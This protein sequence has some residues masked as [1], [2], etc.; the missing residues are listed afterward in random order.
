MRSRSRS[1]LAL[2][3]TAA[4][5]FAACTRENGTLGPAPF[6]NSP[7]VFTDNFG[8]SV[9]FAAF[10]GSKVD[11]LSIDNT[12]KHSGSS[13][14]KITVPS[15]GDPAGSYA[16]GAF[17]VGVPRDLSS[18]NVLSFWAPSSATARARR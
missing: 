7:T 15:V 14:L 8:E 9:N 18:Y 3:A 6:P 13:S 4:L 17:V 12:V 16:G 11:A 1:Y 10:G 2:A 5:A